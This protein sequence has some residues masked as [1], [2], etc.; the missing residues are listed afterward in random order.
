M[1]ETAASTEPKEAV[2]RPPITPSVSKPKVNKKPIIITALVGLGLIIASSL[3]VYFWQQGIAKGLNQ[4]KTTLNEKVAS[5]S[6]Q[7]TKIEKE[8]T[9]LKTKVNFLEKSLKEAT[10]SAEFGELSFSDIQATHYTY[11]EA[12]VERSVLLI[13]LTAKNETK[14]TLFISAF[15]F[16]L[17]DTNNKSYPLAEQGAFPLP[18]GKVLIFDQPAVPGEAVSG[19]VAFNAPKTIKLF[20][21]YYDTQ[22]FTITIK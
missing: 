1:D 8:N 20:T 14:Q 11:D 5:Q 18:S 15:S 7:I 4:E 10:A 21:L 19:T 16:K 2:N 17:K 3:G 22:Q 13:D 9:D 6:A 12:G